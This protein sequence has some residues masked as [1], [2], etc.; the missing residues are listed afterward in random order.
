[1]LKDSWGE[2]A[3]N[4]GFSDLGADL[5]L[6]TVIARHEQQEPAM[7]GRL[8]TPG[9]DML[10][11]PVSAWPDATKAVIQSFKERACLMLKPLFV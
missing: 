6:H 3:K 4:R 8:L 2:I 11:S 7:N 9:V 5:C 10:F 1:M